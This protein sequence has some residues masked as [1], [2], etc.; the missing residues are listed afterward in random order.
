MPKNIVILFDGTSNEITANRT[1]ILRLYG[2]LEKTPKQVVFYDPGVGT[3]GAESSFRFVR[4]ATEIWGLATGAGLG[5]NVLEAYR[6]L[7]DTYE[8]GDRIYIFGFSRG[9][10]TARVL[11]GFLHSLGLINHTQLNLLHYA[12]RTYKGIGGKGTSAITEDDPAFEGM[13]HYRR[14][15]RPT[16]VPIA[17][18]GLFDTVASVIEVI[19]LVPRLRAHAFTHQNPSVAACRHA[20]ALHERRV[21][22]RPQLW[23][24][25]QPVASEDGETPQDAKEV[26]FSGVHGD[27]G[28]GYPEADSALAKVPLH[29]MIEETRAWGLRYNND[30][31]EQIVLGTNPE[32]TYVAPD[33]SSEPQNSMGQIWPLLEFLPAR[34]RGPQVKHA[35]F[36]VH[37][38]LF[39]PRHVPE[40]AWVH[41]SVFEGGN[42]PEHLPDTYRDG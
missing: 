18:L 25:D 21:M 6:F 3:F 22:F 17:G 36:G 11:A 12:F 1:N 15:L 41:R 23:P 16:P 27:V 2:C 14:A 8:K 4:K 42:A 35:A 29:W 40:N 20:V 30:V 39:Q 10:Y 5:R 34:A 31:I 19:R 24:E 26:W 33:P 13:R 32:K 38:P 28:G 9:A 7:L 37:L